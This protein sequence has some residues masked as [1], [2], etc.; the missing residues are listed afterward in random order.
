[1]SDTSDTRQLFAKYVAGE[2]DQDGLHALEA[3][4]V[5]DAA[6]RSDFIEYLNVDSALSDL[7]APTKF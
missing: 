3:A 2:I 1:M 6:L 7:A 4:L 5:E